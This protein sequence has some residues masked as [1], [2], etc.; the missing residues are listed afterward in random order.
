MNLEKISPS[1]IEALSSDLSFIA[2]N[3]IEAEAVTEDFQ[4]ALNFASRFPENP[5]AKKV[6][7]QI[8]SRLENLKPVELEMIPTAN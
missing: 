7:E 8:R 2:E 6:I 1:E 5:T 3:N 4:S